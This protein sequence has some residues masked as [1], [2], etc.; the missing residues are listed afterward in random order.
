[1]TPNPEPQPER[2]EPSDDLREFIEAIEEAM[3]QVKDMELPHSYYMLRVKLL[4]R[5]AAFSP[6]PPSQDSVCETRGCIDGE[7]VTD[8]GQEYPC[9]NPAHTSQDEERCGGSG[10]K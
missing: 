8:A 4:S 9:P 2:W 7:A 1:M 6:D 10:R 5:I 3:E